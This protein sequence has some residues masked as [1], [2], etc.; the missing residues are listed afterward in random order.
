MFQ[1]APLSRTMSPTSIPPAVLG[2]LRAYATIG[3]ALI[4]TQGPGVYAAYHASQA[5]PPLAL[6]ST[7][8]ILF[9]TS[10]PT[11]F[12]PPGQGRSILSSGMP[13]KPCFPWAGCMS[14]VDV[15]Q[16]EVVPS[17]SLPDDPLRCLSG[18]T[19]RKGQRCLLIPMSP[20]MHCHF[21]VFLTFLAF[22]STLHL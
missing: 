20:Q 8:D 7:T 3:S 5:L 4:H 1:L 22:L 10:P 15:G 18:Q 11:M 9:S 13:P 16:D 6:Y 21:E 2:R 14:N 17:C 19:E 12:P